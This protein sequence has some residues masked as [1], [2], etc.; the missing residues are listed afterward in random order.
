VN[1]ASTDSTALQIV[2]FVDPVPTGLICKAHANGVKVAGLMPYPAEQLHN[3]SYLEA[4]IA[5]QV[6]RAQTYYWDGGNFDFE[7]PLNTT[8]D[9]AALTNVVNR[10][11]TALKA[12]IGD[13]FVVSQDVAWSPAGID[14]RYFEY[15]KLAAIVDQVRAPCDGVG[16]RTPHGILLV[17][18]QP[19]HRRADSALTSFNM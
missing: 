7:S 4:F 8:A 18:A 2:S 17:T 13:F 12:A 6:S 1:G 10:T 19:P 15:A 16:G 5:Q 9:A 11:T 3:E 14:G